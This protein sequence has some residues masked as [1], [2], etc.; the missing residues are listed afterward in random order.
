MVHVH[1]EMMMIAARRVASGEITAPIQPVTTAGVN[2][3]G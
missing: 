1:Y 2:P 3:N